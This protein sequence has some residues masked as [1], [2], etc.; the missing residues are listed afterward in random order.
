MNKALI[1]NFSIIAH[2]DHGKSTLADALMQ[3]TG[4]V[5]DRNRK[6]QFLDQMDIERERGIT[7]KAQTVRLNHKAKDGKT[8]QLN[9]IDT[10][11]HVDF[12]Y[13]VSRSLKACEGVIL[14]VDAAQGVEAQTL[15]NVYMA[16]EHN[17]EIIVV[18]NKVDL[19]AADV[20]GVKLQVEEAIG[21]DTSDALLVS[22]KNLVGIDEVL[23]RVVTKIPAPKMNPSKALRALVFDSWFDIYQGVVILCRIVD[24]HLK[25]GDRILFMNT[26]QDYEVLK[27]GFFSP[28]PENTLQLQQGEVGFLI[29]G[30]KTI[31]GVQVGDTVTHKSSAGLEQATTALD[32][33]KQVK[34]M[35]FSG[36]FPVEAPDYEDLKLALEK[37]SLNDSS[38]TYEVESSGALGFGFRCGFLGLL[39]M[40]IVRERLEREFDLHLISTAPSVVYKLHPTK[41]ESFEL[42]NPAD[43]PEVSKIEYMEEPFVK[44]SIHT[45]ADFVGTILKLCERKRGTQINMEYIAGN[46]V[47]IDYKLPLN[48]MILDFYDQL[49]SLSKGY[50]S[51]EYEF[52]EYAQADLVKLDILLNGESVDALSAIVHKSQADTKGRFLAKKLKELIPRQQYQIAIQAAVG[53]KI[54]AR[55][56]LGALRKD[57]TAKCYGGDIS[58]KRKL[59][60]KQKAGKKRMKQVGKVS[61]PQEAFLAI[62]KTTE[63]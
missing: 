43:M 29:C 32:G 41:G 5:S 34:P 52:L 45:P 59:L 47:V 61:V 3:V 31:K 40:E 13:E 35:V 10:P 11:G 62:L 8:Y 54:L 21:L 49:K 12:A 7:I 22:A 60:E 24:G 57:V 26:N 15:A 44:V 39:H 27:L 55:E 17:L 42:E 38:F 25:K 2:I 19:P 16:I 30:I 33:F 46:R 23:E 51:L 9:L 48:E 37:L 6:E 53:A 56:S 36:L 50:A 58:R 14:V 4:A 18:L 63:N 28:F 1:R 20:E